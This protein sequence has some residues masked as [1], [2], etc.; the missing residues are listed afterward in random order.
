M[1]CTDVTNVTSP[2]QKQLM[3]LLESQSYC[4]T[5]S[6]LCSLSTLPYFL[7]II[8]TLSSRPL[9]KPKNVFKSN[10]AASAIVHLVSVQVLIENLSEANDY[11]SLHSSLF[12][13][14]F[15]FACPFR[16]VW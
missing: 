9:L 8:F 5:A 15:A 3:S 16:S 12:C 1:M 7:F 2:L 4:L 11:I 13:F 6:T 10:F 14:L